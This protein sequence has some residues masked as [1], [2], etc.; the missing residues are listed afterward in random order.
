MP[1][2]P[3]RLVRSLANSVAPHSVMSR[4]RVFISD[5]NTIEIGDFVGN[6]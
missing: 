2:E 4:V 1:A 6:S 5:N 3:R